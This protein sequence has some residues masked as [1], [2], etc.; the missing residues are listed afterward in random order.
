MELLTI[1]AVV[2]ACFAIALVLQIGAL[3]AILWVLH[4]RLLG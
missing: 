4:S 1:L 2:P 3:K